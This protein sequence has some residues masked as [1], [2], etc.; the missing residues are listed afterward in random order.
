MKN[1]DEIIKENNERDQD[2]ID[3]FYFNEELL[4]QKKA[5][6]EKQKSLNTFLEKS[7]KENIKNKNKEDAIEQKKI[8]TKEERNKKFIKDETNKIFKI[9]KT[10]NIKQK[11]NQ[12]N[13]LNINLK[14][15]KKNENELKKKQIKNG[16]IDDS[17]NQENYVKVKEKN[18]SDKEDNF[19]ENTRNEKGKKELINYIQEKKLKDN[20]IKK[21]ILIQKENSKIIRDEEEEKNNDKI[22]NE[23]IDGNDINNP[24]NKNNKCPN[25]I[26]DILEKV[27]FNIKEK[28]IQYKLVEENVYNSQGKIITKKEVMQLLQDKKEKELKKLIFPK[29]NKETFEFNFGKIDQDIWKTLLVKCDYCKKTIY[30]HNSTL[31]EHLFKFHF[32][33]M[34]Q[35]KLVSEYE[36][37]KIIEG[38]FK[39][40]Y[41]KYIKLHND[42][43]SLELYYR[44]LEG[45]TTGRL[46]SLISEFRKKFKNLDTISTADAQKLLRGRLN[47][48]VANRNTTRNCLKK[49]KNNKK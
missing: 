35:N 23:K 29:Y 48:M 12:T 20:E 26:N 14:E 47:G 45:H 42:L 25:N 27:T 6:K 24:D 34:N 16:Q 33:E 28:N 3:V 5:I 40:R 2:F 41:L 30:L 4:N 32:N 44:N 17:S 38:M 22:E 36:Q 13:N 31:N 43:I 39:Y 15:N 19:E 1:G 49:G 11:E 21:D 9:G 10:N 7:T 8:I 37:K 46:A 18:D